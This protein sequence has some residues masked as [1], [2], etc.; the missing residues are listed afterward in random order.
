M[1]RPQ[2]KIQDGRHAPTTY[3]QPKRRSFRICFLNIV[4]NHECDVIWESMKYPGS[5]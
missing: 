1:F 5:A 3:L 2:M 4:V